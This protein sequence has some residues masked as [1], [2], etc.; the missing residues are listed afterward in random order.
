MT[1]PVTLSTFTGEVYRSQENHHKR[2]NVFGR[3]AASSDSWSATFFVNV[4][5]LRLQCTDSYSVC[6]HGIANL[7]LL[8]NSSK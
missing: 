5:D 8:Y 3:G 6:L 1:A 2:E 4:H 7:A